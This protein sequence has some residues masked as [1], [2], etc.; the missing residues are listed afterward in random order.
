MDAAEEH[1]RTTL[2][3]LPP[4]WEER[5]GRGLETV[6][7]RTVERAYQGPDLERDTAPL[8]AEQLS[9]IAKAFM[10]GTAAHK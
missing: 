9:I 4:P 1:L 10:E 8:T 7:P 2:G 3:L 5:T 6:K